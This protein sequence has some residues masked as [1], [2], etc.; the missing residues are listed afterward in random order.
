MFAVCVGLARGL[1]PVQRERSGVP[2]T[3]QD[4]GRAPAERH[5]YV[6]L[7]VGGN[8][9]SVPFPKDSKVFLKPKSL[10]A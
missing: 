1:V 6:L 9:F 4:A 7:K 2:G 10:T 8:Y 3:A 5:F